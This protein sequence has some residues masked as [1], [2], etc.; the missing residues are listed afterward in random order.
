[1]CD[2]RVTGPKRRVTVCEAEAVVAA[3]EAIAHTPRAIQWLRLT[4]SE[5]YPPHLRME[6]DPFS[7]TF[8]FS[9]SLEYLTMENVQKPSNSE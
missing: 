6:T 5:V 3:S 4:L 2:R 8:E 9:S 7:E 1:V